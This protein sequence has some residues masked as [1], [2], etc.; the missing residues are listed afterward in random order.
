MAEGRAQEAE[1]LTKMIQEFIHGCGVADI[2]PAFAADAQL[3][4]GTVH[5]LQKQGG[6]SVSGGCGGRYIIILREVFKLCPVCLGIFGY[7]IP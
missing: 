7:F 1:S 2:T 4:S 3:P 6:R 5:A